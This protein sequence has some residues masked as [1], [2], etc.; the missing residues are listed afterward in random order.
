MELVVSRRLVEEIAFFIVLVSYPC[1]VA[2]FL[3]QL[4]QQTDCKPIRMF[5]HCNM[6]LRPALK[7]VF[8]DC[9]L[10]YYPEVSCPSVAST[11]E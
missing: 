6:L 9:F 8:Y 1:I 4:V 5:S 2:H 10:V 11:R 3:T 7:H